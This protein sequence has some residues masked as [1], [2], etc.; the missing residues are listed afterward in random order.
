MDPESRP[1][2]ADVLVA[3]PA[4]DE[5]ATIRA[6]LVNVV[7]AIRRAQR[8]GVVARARVMVAAHRCRDTTASLALE[9]LRDLLGDDGDYEVL[10]I[11]EVGG[12]G[13]PRHAAVSRGL[14]AIGADLDRTW[15][16]STDADSLV[17]ADWIVH[18]LLIA[19]EAHAPAVAGMTSLHAH[20][21]SRAARLA[22]EEILRRG[23]Y[24]DVEGKPAHS[25]VYGANLAV[26]ADA[27]VAVGGFPVHGHAEDQRLVDALASAGF[28]IARSRRLLVSTSG[29][30]MGR[31][32]GGLAHLLRSLDSG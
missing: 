6:C 23:L 11:G 13:L 5:G 19:A 26:R 14:A 20:T 9:V 3:I 31:A 16:F 32:A 1:P 30:T 29:R 24:V 27:Y 25:H 15:V 17:P 21:G 18:S 22:Y 4:H 12:V 28:P 10:V 8:E 7:N 2:R